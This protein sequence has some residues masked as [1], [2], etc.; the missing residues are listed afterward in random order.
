MASRR[1]NGSRSFTPI[2][3]KRI[4]RGDLAGFS[5]LFAQASAL[6]DRHERYL[7][8]NEL[9]DAAI[10]A[11]TVAA[12]AIAQQARAAG[13]REAIALL[14]EEPRE[15]VLL[16]QA[17]LLMSQLSSFGAAQALFEAAQRL[18]PRLTNVAGNLAEV[19]RRRRVPA[20]A[21]AGVLGELAPRALRIAERAQPAE[22]MTVSLCMIVKD[23]EEM[24]P[25]CLA[26]AAPAVDE[27]VIVDTGS[28]DRTIEIAKSFG[29]RVIERE[30][31]G[32]FS[33]ARN[34][35]LD[36]ATSDWLLV[37]DADEVLVPE[38]VPQLRAQ[39]G[40]TWREAFYISEINYTGELDDGTS[41]THTTV[42]LM[43]ARPEHR[44]TGR[45]HE[46]I[47]YALPTQ[48]PERF[49]TAPVRVEH[50]GYLGAVRDAKEKSRRNLELLERQRDEGDVSAFMHF[51]LGSEYY[52]LDDSAAALAEFERS[53]ELLAAERNDGPVGYE[54]ALT[55]RHVTTLRACG[56]HEEAIALAER[57]LE[58]F[59]TFTDLVFEQGNAARM[60]GR[61]DEAVAYY[62]RCLQMGDA[63]GAYTATVGCGTHHPTIA[64]AD[65]ALE[66]GDTDR[67][68]ELLDSCLVDFPGFFGLVLPFAN[69]LL[70]NG[71]APEDVVAR[72]EQRVAK[73]TPTVRFMLAT[74]LY[75]HGQT[76][77]AEQQFRGV[78]EQQPSSARARV[79]LAEAL[80]SQ[81]RWEDAA[82]VAAD[83]LDGDTLAPL[84]RRSELFARLAGGDLDGA[85]QVLEREAQAVAAQAPDADGRS[86]PVLEE[87]D[88]M[89]FEAWLAAARGESGDTILP[90][91]AVPLL[92]VALEALLR[93]EAVEA[94]GMLVPLLD[95][96]PIAPREQR[97]LRAGMYFRRGFL[98]S[99]AEE[100]IAVCGADPT[101]VRALLGLAQVAA[102]QQM[103]DEALDFAREAH[104]LDPEDERAARLL[105]QLEPLAA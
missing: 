51:N 37:L 104:A 19:V 70:V 23:E 8:R 99:A 68:V 27:I 50:F 30:W 69:A 28:S 45:L 85:A 80:L 43:R 54:F 102:A 59:P 10:Q 31:T 87:G 52:A 86:G 72:V 41:T 47:L 64:L 34:V 11:G 44:Y 3:L 63:P 48:L 83:L 90:L 98:A 103:T 21:P 74:A 60:L 32:D 35:G 81:S 101:D 91:E 6:D 67:A 77:A 29:A 56:R 84:A 92:A 53:T 100:W 17:G 4:K 2:A 55:S 38:D 13:A 89:L 76:L 62:E 25:R 78:L 97:E 95:R 88:R 42:R 1:T 7:A 66:A 61:L 71:G 36:A 57:S 82:A 58:R 49:A 22:G 105:E 33:Q 5:A 16:N 96:C 18:D 75:E 15:P 20:Q 9:V 12:P 39:L 73:L 93:V 94:F 24:L 46:Q 40:Q 79:A 26:A 65:I 14:E